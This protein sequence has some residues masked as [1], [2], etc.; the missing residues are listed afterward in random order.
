[1]QCITGLFLLWVIAMVALWLA[2][3][4]YSERIQALLQRLTKAIDKI[5]GDQ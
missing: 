1:M 3:D 4:A 2:Q 5:T